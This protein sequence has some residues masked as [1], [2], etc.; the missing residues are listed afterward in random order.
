M[1]VF[2]KSI[3]MSDFDWIFKLATAI[4]TAPM[5]SFLFNSYYIMTKDRIIN[6]E[7]LKEAMSGEN[8]DNHLIEVLFRS[9]YKSR[10]VSA[11]EIKIL[12]SQTSP[13]RISYRYA[14]MNNCLKVTEL[15]LIDGNLVFKFSHPFR[16]KL[17]RAVW[18]GFFIILAMLMCFSALY[19]GGKVNDYIYKGE[20]VYNEMC[21]F[22]IILI[23][24]LLILYN[25]LMLLF[26]SVLLATNR[27]KWI[28]D[29]ISARKV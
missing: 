29:I 19:L 5:L 1:C 18:G 16:T 2:L 6:V 21:I 10:Y 4:L 25:Y 20:W 24:L 17:R 26:L 13:M 9:I 8:V 22:L 28:N 14:L 12:M 11:E 7:K 3:G 27:I 23:L 15:F